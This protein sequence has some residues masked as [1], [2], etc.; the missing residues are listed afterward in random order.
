MGLEKLRRD[1]RTDFDMDDP[2]FGEVFDDV[3]DDLVAHCPVA[4]S[5][6]GQGYWVVNRYEDV[7]ELL[8]DWETFSSADGIIGANRPPDQPLFKPNEADPPEHD[9]LRDAV[10]KYFTPRSV[11]KHEPEIRRIV[12]GLVDEFIEDG[13][14]ELV[15]Q[16]AEPFPPVAFCQAIAHMPKEDMPFLQRVFNDAITGPHDDRGVNW[17]K[18]QDYMAEFLESRRKQPRQDDIV[19]AILHFEFPDGQPYTHTDRAGSLAQIVAAG[20]T[21][22]GAVISGGLYHLAGNPDDRKRLQADPSQIP[23][24][25]EEF[26]R[27]FVSAPCDGRRVMK[28][29]EVAGTMIQGPREDRKGDYVIYNLGGA[30]RDPAV[31]DRPGEL[32]IDRWPNRHLSFAV[33]IHRCIGLHLARLNVRVAIETFLRRIPE[34]AVRPGFEPHFQGGITRSLTRLDLIFDVPGSA[35]SR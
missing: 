31:F 27:V 8:Q 24:A 19:D 3:C 1:W 20:A 12:E 23:R 11:A 6:V 18:G 34:F 26:L 10:S 21:T 13:E 32:L 9:Q 28:D 14:V 16:Y 7:H 25:V 33:G 22:T 5:T 30:N 35:G 15:R 17:L 29:V 2:E 4:H